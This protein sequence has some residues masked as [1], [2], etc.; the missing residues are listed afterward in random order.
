M[1]RT[2]KHVLGPFRSQLRVL[3]REIAGQREAD[4]RCCGVTLAQCHALLE[5][6]NTELSLTHLSA[7]LDLD[8]ST[9]SRTVDGLVR[10]GLVVRAEDPA[11]RRLLRLRLTPAGRGK[12]DRINE[13]CNRYY[14]E[15]LAGMNDRD[16]RCVLR[17]VGLLADRMRGLRLSLPCSTK[18]NP[19]GKK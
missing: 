16:R 5:L 14:A 1:N 13:E 18:E 2:E 19:H 15:L 12:V 9:L 11:D 3:E 6:E 8:I 4:T 7:V 17:S 10:A